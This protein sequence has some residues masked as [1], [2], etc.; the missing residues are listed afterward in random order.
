MLSNYL[1]QNA[2]FCVKV[3]LR[4]PLDAGLSFDSILILTKIEKTVIGRVDVE[5]G[6]F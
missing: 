1:Q 3:L 5:K 2:L 4:L 6:R